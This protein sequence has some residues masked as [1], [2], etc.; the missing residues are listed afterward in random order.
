MKIILVFFTVLALIF[1]TSCGT[2]DSDHALPQW[3][4]PIDGIWIAQIRGT[5]TSPAFEILFVVEKNDRDGGYYLTETNL[6]GLLNPQIQI[7]S[8]GEFAFKYYE[9]TRTTTLRGKFN[10]SGSSMDGDYLIE[11]FIFGFRRGNF[12]AYKKDG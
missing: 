11:D 6:T 1:L 12:T 9:A 7:T 2:S 10:S 8:R 4:T 5:S 3:T